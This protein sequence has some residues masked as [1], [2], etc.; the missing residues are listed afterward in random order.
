MRLLVSLL[1]VVGSMALADLRFREIAGIAN[2][3]SPRSVEAFLERLPAEIFQDYVLM[4]E[5]RSLQFASANEPR[6]ILF[7]GGGNLVVA[8][9]GHGNSVEAIEFN[10]KRKR[11]DFYRIDFSRN[12][13]PE[14]SPANPKTCTNCHGNPLRPNWDPYAYW[15][16]AYDELESWTEEEQAQYADFLRMSGRSDR[17]RRL[18][19]LANHF[20]RIDHQGFLDRPNV[21]LSNQLAVRNFERLA[22]NLKQRNDWDRIK[23][24]IAAASI[25][26]C[27]SVS[28]TGEAT[29]SFLPANSAKRRRVEALLTDRFSRVIDR[30]RNLKAVE[31]QSILV[32]LQVAGGDAP[33][34]ENWSLAIS[35]SA[36]YNREE[37]IFFKD[38]LNDGIGGSNQFIPWGIVRVD[39]EIRRLIGPL[40]SAY[41]NSIGPLPNETAAQTHTRLLGNLVFQVPVIPA[42]RASDAC[43]RMTR[44]S[45]RALGRWER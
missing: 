35:S 1:A 28:P 22:F 33:S 15:P 44:R 5:S 13:A 27:V 8:Y 7:G 18:P 24:A 25:R 3:H 20:D 31:L 17:Y 36:Y 32:I 39:R 12:A 38:P 42:L 16:G 23:F 10:R 11:W 45:L 37:R 6:V 19:F 30:R 2:R 9:G 41:E 43:E 14:V 34:L 26:N 40:V 4:R 29:L 21:R